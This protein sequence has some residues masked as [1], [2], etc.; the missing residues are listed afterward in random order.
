VTRTRAV[1]LD[2][3][4]ALLAER[5]YAGFTMDALVE[6]TGVS[7]TTMYK[8]WPSRVELVAA[9]VRA[10]VS[11]VAVPDSGDL[12]EDL[13]V[14][15]R[16]SLDAYKGALWPGL[17][18]VMEAA[19]H[20]PGLRQAMRSVPAARFSAVRTVLERAAARGQL[21]AGVDLDIAVT[22]LVGAF[23]FRLRTTDLQQVKNEVPAI[24]DAVLDGLGRLSGPAPRD[25]PHLANQRS[26]HERA[27]A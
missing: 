21:R 22:I 5:G 16:D 10:M 19:G 26:L 8:H 4:A 25:A 13:A 9:T 1:V 12:R 11:D 24:L 15:A 20:D 2:A 3:A 23:F 6:R 18:S 14:L 27:L 7:K 17:A